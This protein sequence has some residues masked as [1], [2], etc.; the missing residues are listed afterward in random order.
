MKDFLVV[1]E[2]AIST[3]AKAL[4]EITEEQSTVK[5]AVDKWSQKEILGHLIDSA[6]NNAVR[7]VK[8]QTKEDMI[9]APYDQD[10]WVKVQSYQ[11]REWNEL[12]DLWH[13]SNFH[14]LNIIK[15]IPAEVLTRKFSYHNFDEIAWIAV[16][17]NKP[18]DLNYLIRDY[19]GHMKHHLDQIFRSDE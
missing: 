6:F 10:F 2:H 14:I 7:F 13:T 3:S 11:E 17:K 19:L 9:F 16:D 12:I 15:H 1:F 18:V 4:R 5:P 8:C